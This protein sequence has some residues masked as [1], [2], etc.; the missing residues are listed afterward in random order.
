MN[1]WKVLS[2]PVGGEMVYQVYRIRNPK[3][4]MHAGNIQTSGGLFDSEEEAERYAAKL[5]EGETETE[6]AL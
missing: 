5:N 4:P 1:K 6:G 3:E 2:N